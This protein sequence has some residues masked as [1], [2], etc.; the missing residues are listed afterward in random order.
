MKRL[1]FVVM[2]SCL[3]VSSVHARCPA[4][5]MGCTDS[6]YEQKIKDRI[7]QGKRE[8]LKSDTTVR[9]RVKAAGRTVQDCTDCATKVLTDKLGGT[10]VQK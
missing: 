5:D 7:E 2:F 4:S 3:S 8:V 1:L 6:N 10:A 9:D